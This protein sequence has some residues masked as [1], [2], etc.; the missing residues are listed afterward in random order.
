MGV[1]SHVYV[2]PNY[3]VEVVLCCRWG[4]DNCSAFVA[5]ILQVTFQLSMNVGQF[6][7]SQLHWLIFVKISGIIIA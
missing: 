7:Q 6:T 4:C 2:Q 3:S 5:T 1:Q